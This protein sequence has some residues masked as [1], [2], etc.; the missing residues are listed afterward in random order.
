MRDDVIAN[1][2]KIDDVILEGEISG[3]DC[4]LD[5]TD[6]MIQT[7]IEE[8]HIPED[9]NLAD[10]LYS[11]HDDF[12]S[13]S[14]ESLPDDRVAM[15]DSEY[16]NMMEYMEDALNLEASVI[17]K[18]NP[19]A[20]SRFSAEKEMVQPVLSKRHL[21]SGDR[22]KNQTVGGVPRRKSPPIP[23]NRP[24]T[25]VP[26]ER[27]ISHFNANMV[28]QRIA[29]WRQRCLDGL[30]EELFEQA[31]KIAKQLRFDD[32]SQNTDTR[33]ELNKL[34]SDRNKCMDLEQL[35]YLEKEAET[36]VA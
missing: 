27:H 32:L 2:D 22:L 17:S 35:V 18:K 34:V 30:G 6:E 25:A 36:D 28:E 5:L 10:T 8:G 14:D 19:L 11:L 16:K 13:S 31:Y 20:S 1:L 12:E 33:K 3:E 21:D 4:S 7:L 23:E 15:S 29:N 26:P 24:M 9:E